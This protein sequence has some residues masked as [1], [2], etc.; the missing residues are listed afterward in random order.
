[1]PTAE[2]ILQTEILEAVNTKMAILDQDLA[3]LMSLKCFKHPTAGVFIVFC[4]VNA[5][6]G[7]TYQEALYTAR[8]GDWVIATRDGKAA[9]SLKIFFTQR[10]REHGGIPQIDTPQTPNWAAAEYRLQRNWQEVEKTR[11]VLTQQL[12]TATQQNVDSGERLKV[13]DLAVL[14]SPTCDIT[15]FR[16]IV[17]FRLENVKRL[18]TLIERIRSKT[19][20][21]MTSW[22]EMRFINGLFE[23]RR[24]KKNQHKALIPTTVK[25]EPTGWKIQQNSEISTN[26]LSFHPI[27]QMVLI[28][29]REGDLLNVQVF[30][31]MA[32]IP[33]I[34]LVANKDG[35]LRLHHL[36]LDQ[37]FK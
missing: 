13:A 29:D 24:D 15:E 18:P 1:M 35:G 25:M 17:L 34:R 20:G 33:F 36:D 9:Q 22:E 14:N 12:T 3:E 8:Y 37:S 2:Q 16:T 7:D 23:I 19:Q 26:R 11:T 4:G 31:K 10:L 32:N 21:Q 6:M 5:W 30:S 28:L 27:K